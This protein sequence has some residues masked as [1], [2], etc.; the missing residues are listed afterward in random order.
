MGPQLSTEVSKDKMATY[1]ASPEIAREPSRLPRAKGKFISNVLTLMTGNGLSQLIN[2]AGTLVLARLFAPDAF[3]SFA[4]F[5]T[6]VSFLSVLGGGRYELA[7]MLPEKDEEAANVL[8]LAVLVLTGVAGVSLLTVALFHTPIARLL[9]DDRL[10]LWLWAAPF[11][12]F[13]NGLYQ[14]QGVWFG[15]MKRFRRLATGRV[16]QSSGTVL[17]QL[18]LLVVHP[19]GFAL[20]GGWIIGQ[21]IGTLFLVSQL[22]YS[23]GRF[24]WRARNWAV[25]REAMGRYRNFPIYKA[26]H[27]FVS[28][29]SSQLVVVILRM[30]ADLNLVGLYSMAARAVYLPVTLVASSMNEV[31]Y[32]KAATELKH[33]R[34]ERFVTRLLRIQL[35]LAGPLLVLVAYDAKLIFGFLLGSKWVAAGSFAAILAFLSFLYFLTS[36]LDRLFDVRGRQKICL[37]L[38]ITGNIVSL[39]ALA[40]MLKWRPQD[41]ALAIGIYVVLQMIF[42]IIWL[43]FAYRVA[44]FGMKGLTLLLRDAVVSVG[45]AILFVGTIHY[46]LHG[47]PAFLVSAAVALCMIAISFVR[48]VSTGTA[49]SS[50]TERFRQ[51]WAEQDTTLKGRDDEEFRWAQ[52]REL[53][54]LFPSRM[55]RRV[56]E[57]G[58][59]DGGLFPYLDVPAENYKG[60]D[61]SPQFIERFKSTYP[62]V[63]LECTEGSS[64]LDRDTQYDVILMDA[65]VQHFDRAMLE[66]HLQNARH[67]VGKN[68]RLIWGSIPQRKHRRKYDAG[69]WSPSG[70]TSLSRFIKSWVGRILG[71]DAMGYW[72]EPSE[73]AALA[74]KYGFYARFALSNTSPYRFHAV[75]RKRLVV[76]EEKRKNQISGT[77]AAMTRPS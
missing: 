72:Y 61:F 1:T 63:Q 43:V 68:G 30:F 13:I 50:T 39:G 23:D 74:R 25:L 19:G 48:Y 76:A 42:S 45:L 28:N 12:L 40:L 46:F 9:G 8:F 7:I 14:V 44:E 26:P 24:L 20:V 16:F 11:A 66:Q 3:G 58:C 38:E 57:I 73:I 62:E 65:I 70:R 75:L 60:I 6:L 2:I 10:N 35:V 67:M 56:L 41:A 37:I 47:W 77:A 33:G 27:S 55:P 31:F 49:L 15:R 32:E 69:K 21:S 71:M 34:L 52:A 17:G 54:N 51:F 22:L 29:A 64:Y 18:G 53:K 4:L 36:W 59:G 5:V